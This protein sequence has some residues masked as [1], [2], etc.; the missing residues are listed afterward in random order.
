MRS[1]R[2]RI[3][4][5]ELRWSVQR[6]FSLELRA[7]EEAPFQQRPLIQ[8]DPDSDDSESSDGYDARSNN[9]VPANEQARPAVPTPIGNQ[10]GEQLA[11]REQPDEESD[12]NLQDKE[13]LQGRE[14]SCRPAYSAG[15]GSTSVSPI[16][17]RTFAFFNEEFEFFKLN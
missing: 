17:I 8:S 9:P 13:V 10:A 16:L 3:S 6:L 14:F 12:S 2:L 1:V 7:S 15:T 11:V 5:G 4:N